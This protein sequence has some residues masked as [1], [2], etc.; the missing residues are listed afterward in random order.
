MFLIVFSFP[1]IEEGGISGDG[2]QSLSAPGLCTA[3]V[4][5]ALTEVS[6]PISSRMFPL[7]WKAMIL[8]ELFMS[9]IGL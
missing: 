1:G 7:F 6:S 3:M 9:I 5:L 8:R 4:P 2:E